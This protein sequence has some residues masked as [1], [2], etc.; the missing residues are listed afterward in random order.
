MKIL[1]TGDVQ[2]GRDYWD[3]EKDCPNN[4]L[5]NMIKYFNVVDLVIF[6]LESVIA[7][8][9]IISESEKIKG[10]PYHILSTDKYLQFIKKFTNTPI[11]VAI[12]N[13]HTFD[14]GLQGYKNTIKILKQNDF[15]FT[16][17]YNYL[18][19]K[20][21]IFFDSTTHW[22][23]FTRLKEKH[24]AIDKL[25]QDNCWFINIDDNKALEHATKIIQSVRNNNNNNNKIII[26][27]IHWGKN[28]VS[29]MEKDFYK[30]DKFAKS[31]IDSGCNIVFGSGAHHV[32]P[33]PYTFY[34]KG[35]IIY[36]LGD[37]SGDFKVNSLYNSLDS[38]SLIYD[39]NTNSIQEIKLSK[40]F[41]G[42]KCGIPILKMF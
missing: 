1:L 11:V 39:T 41:N 15:L 24:N 26:M 20:N 30:E 25:W 10:K 16:Y 8:K 27:G 5:K 28:W 42:T 31:L 4:I 37:L 22:T 34:K 2:F 9:N 35:I 40:E 36:G 6:N 33:V 23:E 13:N 12:I 21:L 29:N 3:D 38:L 17:G 7:K 18:D 14:Y 19:Y 32:V